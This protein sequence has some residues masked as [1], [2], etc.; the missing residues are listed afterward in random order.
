MKKEQIKGFMIDAAR[1]VEKMEHY[2]RLVDFCQEWGF[3]TLIFRLTDDEGCA[4]QFK[5]HPELKTHQGAFTKDEL[6]A[7]VGYASQKGI[8]II[9]EIESFGHT[10]Y[11]TDIPKYN[12]LTDI[13]DPSIEWAN[14]ICPV[15]SLTH[16]IIRDLY[17]EVVS[18]FPSPYFHIGCDETNWGGNEKTQKALEEQSKNEIWA[19]YVNTLNNYVKQLGKKTIIWGDVPIREDA[20]ILS[21]L[22]KDIII[23]DWNYWEQNQD[24]IRRDAQLVLDQGFQ[25]IGS[26]AVNWFMWGPRVGKIQLG[27]LKAYQTVYQSLK[28]PNVL[29]ISVTHWKPQRYTQNSQWDSYALAAEMLNDTTYSFASVL[30]KFVEKHFGTTWNQDW[31]E[32]FTKLYRWT[33]KNIGSGR[34]DPDEPI[35]GIR[36]WKNEADLIKAFSQDT[37]LHNPFPTLITHI[38]QL[39]NTVVRNSEDFEEFQFT[40]ELINHLVWRFNQV[41]QIKLDNRIEK[42]EASILTEIAGKDQLFLSRLDELW[43]RG[44]K[45]EMSEDH[46]WEFK[47]AAAYSQYLKN[48]P[49]ELLK[50]LKNNAG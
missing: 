5:S 41:L 40:I 34:N 29:G 14:G 38:S 17:K 28:H 33:P 25:L 42:G 23:M 3:N 11:I 48:N 32:L 12:H 7:F 43:K 10:K 37:L 26:P 46:I 19:G 1:V 24:S 36:V 8:E 30:E 22:E 47:A 49:Q 21:L 39:K 16:R 2:Y 4:Y 18:I 45:G 35:Y 27:N 31:V 50:L 13:E 44:R 9:P 15:D 6:K 20:E